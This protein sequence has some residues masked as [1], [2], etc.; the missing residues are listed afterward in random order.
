MINEEILDLLLDKYKN[1][2]K[3]NYIQSIAYNKFF[4]YIKKTR[5]E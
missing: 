3:G 4:N 2:Y 5:D 1:E